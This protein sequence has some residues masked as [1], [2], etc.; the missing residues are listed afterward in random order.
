MTKHQF[1][2]ILHF[3][4]TCSL[5]RVELVVQFQEYVSEGISHAAFYGDLVYKL[6]KIKGKREVPRDV[7]NSNVR[8]QDKF[9]RDWSRHYAKQISSR[10]ALLKIVMRLRRRE[11][12]PVIIEMTIGRV[13][14]PS[15]AFTYLSLSIAL[16]VARRRGLYDGTCPNLPR[17]DKTPI[18]VPSDC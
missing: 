13:P 5:C 1:F 14:V 10:R 17:G 7:R 11:Y 15:T 4:Q 6:R 3:C 8:K 12:D 16:C 18:H 2:C 9:R